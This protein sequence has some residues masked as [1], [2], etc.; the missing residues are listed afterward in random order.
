MNVMNDFELKVSSSSC[1]LDEIENFVYG[2]FT[3]R[4][5]MLRKH[6]LCM[7][8]NQLIDDP[9]FFAWDCI[10]LNLRNKWD[11]YLIIRSEHAMSML[12]K[13]LINHL[14]T[15]DG[16]RGTSAPFQK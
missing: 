10:T 2:P 3:S 12:L 11:L 4:F 9:P 15:I 8:K 16:F 7:D 1:Y 5:W 13:L 14:E 6:I